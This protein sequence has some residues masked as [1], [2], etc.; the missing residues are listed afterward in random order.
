MP[1]QFGTEGPGLRGD[2]RVRIAPRTA[3]GFAN[4]VGSESRRGQQVQTPFARALGL[5]LPRFTD[6]SLARATVVGR[7]RALH[8]QPTKE[9]RRPPALFALRGLFRNAV[10]MDMGRFAGAVGFYAQGASCCVDVVV[11]VKHV[12]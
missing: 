3:K 12:L 4:K 6:E 9:S 10:P 8:C 2:Q 11:V 5:G 7:L 1:R